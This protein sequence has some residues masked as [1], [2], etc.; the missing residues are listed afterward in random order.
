MLGGIVFNFFFWKFVEAFVIGVIL[1][2]VI[3]LMCREKDVSFWGFFN[4]G[5]VIG[6]LY[7]ILTYYVVT[8]S[9]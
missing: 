2:M 3:A 9:A 8:T 6:I 4:T 1:R 7:T 5:V